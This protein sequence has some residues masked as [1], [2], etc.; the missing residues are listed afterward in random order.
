MLLP[1]LVG[2]VD[3]ILA[4]DGRIRCFPGPEILSTDGSVEL[5]EKHGGRIIAAGL[6][7]TEMAKRQAYVNQTFEGEH[8]LVIDADEVLLGTFPVEPGPYLVRVHS[9][10][11]VEYR[12]RLILNEGF[13]A[14]GECHW[15]IFGSIDGKYADIDYHQLSVAGKIPVA[16]DLHILHFDFLRSESRQLKKW[17]WTF[18][19]SDP[20]R[21]IQSSY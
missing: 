2:K 15:E 21:V 12:L 11:Y 14:Y 20:V 6:W 4:V 9:P 19:R 5:I 17:Q 16:E 13:L 1:S 7:D 8:L 10:G 18:T 3:E